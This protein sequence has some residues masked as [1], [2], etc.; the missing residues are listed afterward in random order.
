[1]T[2]SGGGCQYIQTIVNVGKGRGDKSERENRLC[3]QIEEENPR[4]VEKKH[5]PKEGLK[6]RRGVYYRKFDP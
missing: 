4:C 1:M 5:N 6:R 3:Q 2:S